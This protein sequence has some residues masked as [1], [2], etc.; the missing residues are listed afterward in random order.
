MEINLNKCIKYKHNYLLCKHYCF[1]TFLFTLN[2]YAKCSRFHDKWKM[3]GKIFF[4]F[5]MPKLTFV[6]YGTLH[7]LIQIIPFILF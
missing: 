3:N 1:T 2:Y 7:T 4:F 5:K 6:E